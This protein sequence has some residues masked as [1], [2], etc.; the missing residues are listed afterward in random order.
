MVEPAANGGI[1][2]EVVW[3][4][5]DVQRLVRVKLACGATLA[6]AVRRSGLLAEAAP[7]HEPAAVAPAF[8]I[9]GRRCEPTEVL[10]DGDRVEIYRPLHA[11]AKARRRARAAALRGQ[12]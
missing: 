2:V 10:R 6:E 11:D 3:A 9:F 5:P 4:L 7:R 8:G 1:E 12:R